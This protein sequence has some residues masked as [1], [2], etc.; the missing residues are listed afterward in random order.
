MD[1]S[2]TISTVMWISSGVLAA[3][4]IVTTI[5]YSKKK[6]QTASHISFL[7]SGVAIHF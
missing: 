5:V 7:P 2:D 1:S 3:T 6:R 4:A